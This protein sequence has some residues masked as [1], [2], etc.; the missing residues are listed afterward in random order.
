M[1]TII[2]SPPTSTPRIGTRNLAGHLDDDRPEAKRTWFW[3]LV[4]SLA[5]AG[6]AFDPAT[7]LAA[8]RLARVRDQELRTGQW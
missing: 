5:Y 2:A 4:E 6:A 7:A 1:T 3:A 8:R